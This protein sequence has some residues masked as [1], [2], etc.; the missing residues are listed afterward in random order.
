M[1]VEISVLVTSLLLSAFFSGM[2]IAFVSS[3]KI[4]LEIQKT[5][6]K[7]FGTLLKTITK[8]PSRF[9][10]SMLVGNNI[11]LV[12]YGIYARIAYVK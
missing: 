8:S 10:V 1:T 3:N 5:Q 11:A 9:I 4:R 6:K 7:S 12:V 2:E